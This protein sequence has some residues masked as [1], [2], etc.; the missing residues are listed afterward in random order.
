LGHFS[1]AWPSLA[2]FPPLFSLVLGRLGACGPAALLPPGPAKNSPSPW[3]VRLARGP[4]AQRLARSLR[5]RARGAV[6]QP[7]PPLRVGPACKPRGHPLFIPFPHDIP[8][9]SPHCS[10][11][12]KPPPSRP[13]ARPRSAVS[14]ISFSSLVPPL[15]LACGRRGRGAR[16]V[17]GI[18]SPGHGAVL[19]RRGAT[20]PSQ[21]GSALARPRRLRPPAPRPPWLHR[22]PPLACARPRGLV[23]SSPARP[24]RPQPWPRR[25]ARG[26]GVARSR[27]RGASARPSPPPPTRSLPRRPWRLAQRAVPA[28]A[29]RSRGPRGRRGPAR[30]RHGE[31]GPSAAARAAA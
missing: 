17:P 20:R 14:P 26:P 22:A 25:L 16:R 9:L 27:G 31:L 29:L 4:A 11:R 30:P 19:A 7:P 12:S 3:A 15:S 6:A 5:L 28:P 18:P 21:R 8:F 1:C 13:F 2:S 24:R 23:R 10:R